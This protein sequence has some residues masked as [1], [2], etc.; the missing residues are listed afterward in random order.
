MTIGRC[1][2]QMNS[3]KEDV[4]REFFDLEAEISFDSY[5][6]VLILHFMKILFGDCFLML[7]FTIEILCLCFIFVL[8]MA[9]T[10]KKSKKKTFP[11]RNSMSVNITCGQV[12]IAIYRDK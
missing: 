11:C 9:R 8:I 7:L 1:S 2:I 3:K 12:N 10:K 5:I 4:T 6:T